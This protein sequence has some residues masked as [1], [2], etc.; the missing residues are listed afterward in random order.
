[1]IGYKTDTVVPIGDVTANVE[2]NLTKAAVTL[3][4]VSD[5]PQT[6]SILTGQPSLEQKHITTVK[7]GDI[8]H[9]FDENKL[10]EDSL[11]QSLYA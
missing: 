7:E 3:I 5:D 6:I 4:V 9:L 2:M 8:L 11:M 1:M 10:D